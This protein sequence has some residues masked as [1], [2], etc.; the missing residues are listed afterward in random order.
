ML[1]APSPTG[2]VLRVDP[3]ICDDDAV[4]VKKDGDERETSAWS[5]HGTF[6]EQLG[7]EPV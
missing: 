2:I 6:G 7:F 1:N 3:V 5:T 4:A